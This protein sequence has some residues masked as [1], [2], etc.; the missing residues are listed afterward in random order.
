[1]ALFTDGTISTIDELLAYESALLD[2]ARTERIDL[3]VKLLLARQEIGI[4]LTA[5]LVERSSG[6]WQGWLGPR[7]ELGNIVVTEPLKKWHL[8]HT[9][10]LVY[11]DAYNSQ[12]ND[13][14]QGKWKEYD[15]LSRWASGALFRIGVGTVSDPVPQAARP[16]LG[17]AAGPQPEATYYVRVA[18]VSAAGEEGNPSELAVLSA[19]AGTLLVV[20]AVEPPANAQSWNVYVGVT[21]GDVTLQNGVPLAVGQT[22]TEPETGLERGRPPGTGQ[23]PQSYLRASGAFLG[24]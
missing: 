22:W 12:L 23:A 15:R 5:F 24:G 17:S 20:E 13:R 19:P 8:F 1:M 4:D 16:V 11:R 18:W 14:Y 6:S 9:L 10:A 2:V 21:I 3:T 7:L